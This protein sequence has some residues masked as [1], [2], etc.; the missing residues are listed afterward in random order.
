[1]YT[2]PQDIHVS[3]INRENRSVP[4]GE[5][6]EGFD[7]AYASRLRKLD[8]C[9]G[10]FVR[11]LKSQGLYDESFIVVTSDHG[12]SL[13]EG[14]RY[15]HAYTLFPEIVRVPLIVHLPESMKKRLQ[16]DADQVSFLTDVTPSLYYL[17]DRRP[18]ISNKVFGRPLF[19][20]TLEEHKLY[21]RDYQL[22]A[23]S[24]GPVW[25]VLR[26]NGRYLY[27]ADGVNYTD[28]FF[29]LKADP[30][31]QR[32]A[33]TDAIRQEYRDLIRQGIKDV[34]T[35]YGYNAE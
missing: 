14:G 6:Y 4:R 1:V 23:S 30:F 12:D 24:Y 3:I 16:W 10:D 27:I 7:G 35:F 32:N 8:A 26:D 18:V 2:Q 29:D 5:S 33:V 31:G 34:N 21:H 28:Y 19:T 22:L 17:M 11:Q 25:G 15:G 20:Q 9:F 13:G